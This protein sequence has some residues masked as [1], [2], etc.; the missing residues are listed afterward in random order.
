MITDDNVKNFLSYAITYTTDSFSCLDANQCAYVSSDG[1]T[2]KG[3]NKFY[4]L[5]EKATDSLLNIK[6]IREKNF[7]TENCVQDALYQS[8]INGDQLSTNE[9]L[10]QILSSWIKERTIILPCRSISL[11]DDL[12]FFEVGSIKIIRSSKLSKYCPDLSIPI[13]VNLDVDVITPAYHD[14]NKQAEV[15]I[16]C[17]FLFVFNIKCSERKIMEKCQNEIDVL[18]SLI[19]FDLDENNKLFGHYRQIQIIESN[20]FFKDYSRKSYIELQDQNKVLIS[21]TGRSKICYE[22]ERDWGADFK[23]LCNNIFTCEKML[24]PYIKN[25]LRLLSQARMSANF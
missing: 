12:D 13:S 4:E 3:G 16:P 1:V 20:P 23:A 21:T 6:S 11:V 24:Y 15:T 19:R 10:S 14:D 7:V 22:I 25:A 17:E 9:F 5:L 18:L 8:A 2:L